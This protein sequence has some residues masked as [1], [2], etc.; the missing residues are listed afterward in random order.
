[1]QVPRYWSKATAEE[2]SAQ[3]RKVRFTCWRSS[4]ISQDDAC[5]SALAAARRVVDA[6]LHGRKRDRY[7]YGASPL[8]E[9]VTNRVTDD[10]GQLVAVVVRNLYG[11]LVLNVERVMFVDI[12]FPEAPAGAGPGFFARLFGRAQPAAEPSAEQK[13][14]ASVEQFVAA[15]PGWNMRLYRTFAGLRG[16]VTHDLFDPA[17]QTS[18][19]ILQRLGCDPL[20]VRLCKAQECFRARLTPKPWRCG[21]YANTLRYPIEDPGAARQFEQWKAKYEDGQRSFATCRFLSTVGSGVIHPEVARIVE[22]HDFVTRCNEPL[23]LA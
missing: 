16:L 18:L 2:T 7:A 14:L 4:N 5:Q 15:H 10:Q 23:A 22:L 21:H 13:A 11:S 8:R 6:M 12:D 9:E 17:S 19:E 1:M 3:G 20:Y